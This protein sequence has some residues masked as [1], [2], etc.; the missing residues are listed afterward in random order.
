[1]ELSHVVLAQVH[2]SPVRH[3][4]DGV[5]LPGRMKR[6]NAAAT[7]RNTF[8]LQI[9]AQ[10]YASRERARETSQAFD[11]LGGTFIQTRKPHLTSAQYTHMHASRIQ[12]IYLE[13]NH[14][15]EVL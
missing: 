9:K 15:T 1:M 8:K 11:F 13:E 4:P 14:G 2:P 6:C 12:R 10:I 5:V 3:T 7:D